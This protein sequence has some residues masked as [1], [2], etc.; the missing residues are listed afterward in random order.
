MNGSLIPLAAAAIGAVA[1]A[2]LL[3]S[4]FAP[5]EGPGLLHRLRSIYGEGS[6][7]EL[8]PTKQ[9]PTDALRAGL[10]AAVGDKLERSE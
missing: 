10:Q 6:D 2:V 5:E 7:E 9:A 1:I 3:F 4:L 8:E